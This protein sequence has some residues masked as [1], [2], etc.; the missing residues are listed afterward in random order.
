MN[1]HALISSGRIWIYCVTFA[2]VVETEYDMGNR[3]HA[4]RTLA[5]IEKS[6]ATLVRLFS[7][8][9]GLTAQQEKELWSKFVHL[10]ERLTGLNN[11]QGFYGSKVEH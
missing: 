2:T 9:N 11:Y 7:Q 4:E 5:S 1:K 3:Q 10:G 6:Y 8:S